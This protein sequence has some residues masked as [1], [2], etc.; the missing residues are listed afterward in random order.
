[1]N[2][3]GGLGIERLIDFSKMT[4]MK[5]GEPYECRYADEQE[6]KVEPQGLFSKLMLRHPRIKSAS[7]DWKTKLLAHTLVYLQSSTARL[8]ESSTVE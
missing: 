2:A 6:K 1:M 7:R 4:C 8:Q 5:T 3:G